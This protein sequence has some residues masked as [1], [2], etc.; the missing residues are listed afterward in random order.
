VTVFEQQGASIYIT[1]CEER[2]N[3]S[4]PQFTVCSNSF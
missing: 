2:T 4:E 3:R 1:L